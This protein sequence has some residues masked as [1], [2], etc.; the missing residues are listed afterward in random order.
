MKVIEQGS[1][2]AIQVDEDSVF[3][4]Q[5]SWE[6]FYN[7]HVSNTILADG[8]HPKPPEVDFTK[9]MIVTSIIYRPSGGY[10]LTLDHVTTDH[11]SITVSTT[12]HRPGNVPTTQGMTQPYIF[13]AVPREDGNVTFNHQVDSPI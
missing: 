7:A 9:E 6:S 10:S 4:D 5:T 2:S 12:E 13:A 11:G 8:T 3:R 1:Q